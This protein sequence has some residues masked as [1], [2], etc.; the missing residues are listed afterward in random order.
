[1]S[2]VSTTDLKRVYESGATEVKAVNGVGL[3]I[4]AGEF[5]VLRLTP[6]TAFSSVAPLS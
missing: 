5:A 2:I 1:M 3:S 6:L 4:E